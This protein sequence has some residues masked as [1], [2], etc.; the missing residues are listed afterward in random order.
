[1]ESR[2]PFA[3]Q[4]AIVVVCSLTAGVLVGMWPAIAPAGAPPGWIASQP[5]LSAIYYRVTNQ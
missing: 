2:V 4:V 3:A 5:T 1:M